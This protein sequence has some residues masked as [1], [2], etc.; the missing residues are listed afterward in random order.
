LR[1]R[2]LW[3]VA[4]APVLVAL[5]MGGSTGWAARATNVQAGD[6]FFDPKRVKIGQ[7]QRVEW[8][9]TGSVDHTVKFEGRKNKF[10]S[11]GETTGRKFTDTGRFPYHCTIHPG[12]DGKVVV[13]DQ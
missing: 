10:I 13:G 12:M 9:N 5:V 4:L 1:S 8:E 11:P 2:R 7:G 3:G 6:N